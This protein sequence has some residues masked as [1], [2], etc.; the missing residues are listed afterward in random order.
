MIRQAILVTALVVMQ[1]TSLS[2]PTPTEFIERSKSVLAQIDGEI[3]VAGVKEP[4]EVLRDRWGVPHIY[5]KSADDLFFAQGFVAAQD[6]L[7]QLDLWRRVNVGELA[8]ALGADAIE[9]D[10]FAR[11]IRYRGDMKAEWESYSPDT[12]QIATAFTNGINAWISHSGDKLPVEFQILGYKPKLWRPE[13]ILG[14]MSGIIMSRNFSDE[15]VRAHL[16]DKLGLEKVRMLM[17]TDPQRD[18]GPEKGL[19]LKGIDSRILKGYQAASKAV[20]FKPSKSESNN[21]A[22]SGTHSASGKPM[23]ASDPHRAISLPALRYLVHLNAPGWNVIGAGEPGLPGVALGH[24][25]RIAWG[26]T[27]V[28]TDQ[29]D[30]FVEETKPGDA[31]MYRVG[32][33]WQKMHTVHEAWH[34]KVNVKGKLVQTMQDR[35]FRHTRHGPVLYLDQERNR[36]YALKWAGSE[37]GGAA[38]LPALAVARAQNHK[39]FLAA[40]ERWKIPSLNFM[41]ADKD[42]NIAWV[43]AAATPIRPKHDG[44][45]PVPGNSGYDWKGYLTVK[46]LPQDLNPKSGWLAT[47]NHNI[48][49]LGYKHPI[50]YEFAAPYRFE[51]VKANLDGKQKLTLDDF[52]RI[53]HDDVSIPGMRLAKLLRLNSWNDGEIAGYA[54]LM[55][56]WDGKLSRESKAAVLYA[57]WVPILQAMVYMRHAGEHWKEVA[58]KS[59]LPTMLA[60][61]ENPSEMWFGKDSHE[62]RRLIIARSFEDAVQHSKRLF[63]DRDKMRWGALH[64]VIFR[65]PLEKMHADY[66]KALNIGPF[67]RTGDGNTPNNTRYDADFKQIHGATYRHLFDLAD[68][69]KGLATSAPGQSGQFGSPHYAD[70]APLWAN[71]EYFPLAYSRKM[72]EEVTR[73]KLIL[74]P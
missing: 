45:L 23:L 65:H 67:E 59:G 4:V 9:A 74:R 28:G 66:A 19:D 64:S 27:I 47:A 37:P 13:D 51:R 12:K 20:G 68:W 63:R 35:Y 10:T 50:A 54:K 70:L 1:S 46:D 36:A 14:R 72:V 25:E 40:L 2:Q 34:V 69:D 61:L 29:A 73:H 39:D 8:E 42:D 48:L 26:I 62:E 38:Y 15:V 3:K 18:F 6:R 41:Y 31:D 17:P 43:A 33:G 30:I 55:Q 53:Q 44:L 11:L 56:E 21:W 16:I 32:D 5:A 71:G 22:V 58:G 24:N 52:K 49:P 7:F 60:A 57:C